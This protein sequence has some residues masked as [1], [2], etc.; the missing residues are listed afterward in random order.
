MSEHNS[1]RKAKEF[2]EYYYPYWSNE[3]KEVLKELLI[4]AIKNKATNDRSRSD[5]YIY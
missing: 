2:V 5:R 1:E 4:M 3:G